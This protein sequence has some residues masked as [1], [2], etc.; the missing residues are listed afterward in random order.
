MY[1]NI[2]GESDSSY[3]YLLQVPIYLCLLLIASQLHQT[4]DS[5][6]LMSA[7]AT[8]PLLYI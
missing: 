6:R 4:L 5:I 8:S 2:K 7:K 1:N 3:K